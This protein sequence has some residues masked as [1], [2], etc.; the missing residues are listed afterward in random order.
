MTAIYR[1]DFP[2]IALGV[3]LGPSRYDEVVGRPDVFAAIPAP[4]YGANGPDLLL[5]DLSRQVQVASRQPGAGVTFCVDASGVTARRGGNPTRGCT[6]AVQ[7][8]NVLVEAGAIVA[9]DGNDY[10]ARTAI[11]LRRD[12]GMTFAATRSATSR[13][14]AQEIIDSTDGSWAA[15]TSIGDHS[16]LATQ[17][18]V[19]LGDPDAVSSA[20]LVA[21]RPVISPTRLTSLVPVPEMV[22]ASRAVP[23]LGLPGLAY[24]PRPIMLMP[25][26]ERSDVVP[27][28][29]GIS[30]LAVAAAWWYYADRKED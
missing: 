26:I 1:V 17:Q 9:P 24:D 23:G 22:P 2:A 15:A 10:A 8:L 3:E 21:R 18:G 14:F 13:E 27:V 4:A 28:V 12:G 7:S 30:L 25:P 16:V 19:L 5:R 6:A 11:V 29:V 20:W